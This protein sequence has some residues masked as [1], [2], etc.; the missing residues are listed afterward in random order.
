MNNKQ[1][2]IGRILV[3]DDESNMRK[4]LRTLLAQVGYSVE[5]ADCAD[6]ALELA[7]SNEFDVILSD[8]CMDGR[9]G[10]E[11]LD[12]LR[13][14]GWDGPF[15]LITAHGSIEVAVETMKRGAFDFVTKPFERDEILQV[16]EKGVAQACATRD[17]PTLCELPGIVYRSQ[18]MQKLMESVGRLINLDSTVLILGE[19]GTGKEVIAKAL[20]DLSQRSRETFVA[21]NCSALPEHLV[22]SELFG[23]E[24]GA[25]TGAVYARPGRFELAHKGTIFLDEVG[26]LPM[27]MQ[28][29]L[30][31]VLQERTIERLGGIAPRD[32]DVR[33]VAA[34]HV[35]LEEAVQKGDFRQDLYY[36]LNVIP[37]QLPP[38]RERIDD[39]EPL[40]KHF[41]SK[42]ASRMN[43]SQLALSPEALQALRRYNWPGNIRE[44]QNLVERSLALLNGPVVELSDLP[45]FVGGAEGPAG[46]SSLL[47]V[48]QDHGAK[49]QKTLIEEA[50]EKTSGNRTHAARLLEI[51]RK[52]LQNK[53]K[54]Y[55]ITL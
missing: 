9:D 33:V 38:L 31:R 11:L 54:E 23:H 27:P 46:G 51:S 19:T 6:T 50:L 16:V 4:V 15:V 37:L 39:I 7:A 18:S 28:V 35:D 44:L 42:L 1:S 17:I 55:G 24:K 12:E 13:Q 30:L 21:V 36:R 3:V 10:L 2:T 49:L 53:I 32:V 26:D 43:C 22:E 34:T 45:Q 8:L 20:H 29:K 52:T 40:W 48:A 41:N 25:F 14:R 47:G 5:E